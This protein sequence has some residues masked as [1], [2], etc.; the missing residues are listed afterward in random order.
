MKFRSSVLKSLPSKDPASNTEIFKIMSAEIRHGQEL[1]LLLGKH[2]AEERLA[3][4]LLNLSE[5]F[6]NAIVRRPS[7]T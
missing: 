2:N 3:T 7:S 6:A 5:Q 4:F 1:L